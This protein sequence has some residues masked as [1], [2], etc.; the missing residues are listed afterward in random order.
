MWWESKPNDYQNAC[1]VYLLVFFTGHL[2]KFN[3]V[4]RQIN[5]NLMKNVI[6][7]MYFWM[8]LLA[9]KIKTSMALLNIS[10]I[11][12][13]QVISLIFESLDY[14]HEMN[15]R[16]SRIYFTVKPVSA[17]ENYA[18]TRTLKVLG[19]FSGK[20][21]YISNNSFVR[22]SVTV[23]WK[24]IINILAV[25]TNS[26]S[27]VW[28]SALCGKQVHFGRRLVIRIKKNNKKNQNDISSYWITDT[29]VPITV[30]QGGLLQGK[31]MIYCLLVGRIRLHIKDLLS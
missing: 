8:E 15:L 28:L 27:C 4:S 7:K 11:E 24:T 26:K 31:G 5:P 2:S 20:Y 22:F 6:K 19:V 12:H 17:W 29:A 1:F 16:V 23:C 9:I 13:F 10:N 21:Y 18:N 3:H 14:A 25:C 30:M